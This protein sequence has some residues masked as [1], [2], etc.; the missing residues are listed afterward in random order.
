MF[1]DSDALG[2]PVNFGALRDQQAGGKGGGDR[3]YLTGH[4]RPEIV[5]IARSASLI[6]TPLTELPADAGKTCSQ[7][8]QRRGFR[9]LA[10][11]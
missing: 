4:A 6:P 11:L 1:R 9:D 10:H 7:E 8:Q 5:P 3:P 2:A